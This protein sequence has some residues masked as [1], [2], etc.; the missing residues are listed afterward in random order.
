M[1]T[2]YGREGGDL[3]VERARLDGVLVLRRQRRLL[4]RRCGCR[5]RESSVIVAL[6][7]AEEGLRVPDKIK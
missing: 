6:D 1:S 3:G 4:Q 5:R 2:L 7:E